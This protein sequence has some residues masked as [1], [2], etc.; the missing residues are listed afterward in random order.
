MNS[1]SSVSN[2]KK[3]VHVVGGGKNQAPIVE[4]LHDMGHKV[5]ITDMFERPFCRDLADFFF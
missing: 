5:L 3:L 1:S 4:L 2:G